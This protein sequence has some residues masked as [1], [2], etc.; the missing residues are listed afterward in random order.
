MVQK[1]GHAARIA[2]PYGAHTEHLTGLA[3]SAHFQPRLGFALALADT[4]CAQGCPYISR[5]EDL[6]GPANENYYQF[7]AWHGSQILCQTIKV[8]W[9]NFVGSCLHAGMQR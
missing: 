2:S 9:Q 8:Q 6:T 1:A 3:W 7:F 4:H 5:T